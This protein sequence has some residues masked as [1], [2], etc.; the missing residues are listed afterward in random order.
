MPAF[1]SPFG[2]ASAAP[3]A[4]ASSASPASRTKAKAS[5]IVA[6]V[7]PSNRSGVWTVCPACRNSSANDRTPSVSPWMWWYS[8][9]SAI[10]DPPESLIHEYGTFCNASLFA[11]VPQGDSAG[12]RP[13]RAARAHRARPGEGDQPSPSHDASQPAARAGSDGDRVG[14][15]GRAAEEHR[16]APRQGAHGGR[17]P[18]DREDSAGAGDRGAV[19]R[20]HGPDVLL[21]GGGARSGRRRPAS[22]LQR[23][24]GR[25]TGVGRGARGREI[26]GL[27]PA[28]AHLGGTGVGVLGADGG[29]RNRV[30]PAAAVGRD[31]VRLRGRRLP[32][33]P[34]DPT[35][36]RQ[37]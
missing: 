9:T 21:R 28:R 29:A 14:R 37:L 23:L 3:L 30:R 2:S 20:P 33:R 4:F 6:N 18:P 17:T 12:L 1:T 5:S 10:L 25:R 11:R 19:L 36:R 31:R 34:S 15:R 35:G 22:R 13:C 7:R 8:N 32:D 16:R 27:H 26:V 24:R